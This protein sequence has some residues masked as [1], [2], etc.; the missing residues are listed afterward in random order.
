MF[1]ELIKR[2]F[3]SEKGCHVTYFTSNFD[4]SEVLIWNHSK[5][6]FV[7]ENFFGAYFSVNIPFFSASKMTHIERFCFY[8][9]LIKKRKRTQVAVLHSCIAMTVIF[10]LVLSIFPS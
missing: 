6:F 7:V 10:L 4:L 3:R 1:I 5:H 2:A 8:L 9:I